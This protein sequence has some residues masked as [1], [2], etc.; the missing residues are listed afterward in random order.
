M[1]VY[2]MTS[3]SELSF[4]ETVNLV[5]TE[6]K[7][8][9]FGII[10]DIDMKDTMSDKLG[11]DISRYRILGACNPQYAYMAI[12]AEDHAGL[13]LPCNVVVHELG[14]KEVEVT[15]LDPMAAMEAVSNPRLKA[16]AWQVRQ[17]LE[18][19]IERI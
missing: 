14:S 13:F 6:L 1:S 16:V 3:I 9:G 11:I 7:T 4:D 5:T 17:K 8:A 19:V 18:G 2:S 10:T 12:R 15:V